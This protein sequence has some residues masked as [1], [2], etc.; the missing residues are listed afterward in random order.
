[1]VRAKWG[2][3]IVV[4]RPPVNV[5]IDASLE[6]GL[7]DTVLASKGEMVGLTRWSAGFL[8]KPR[9]RRR[10]SAALKKPI[11]AYPGKGCQ[12]VREQYRKLPPMIV[13]VSYPLH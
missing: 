12:Q 2:C 13:T 1:M 7:L 8:S 6:L 3:R 11:E 10:R 9:P 5:E 4:P